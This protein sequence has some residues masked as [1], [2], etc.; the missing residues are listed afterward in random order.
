MASRGLL[1]AWFV[2]LRT[3]ISALVAAILAL[4]LFRL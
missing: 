3:A 2:D 4:A 1:P